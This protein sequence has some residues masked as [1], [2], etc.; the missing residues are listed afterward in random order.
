MAN[1][2][3]TKQ[4]KKRI[5]S[6]V[7]SVSLLF[8]YLFSIEKNSQNA[9]LQF[10]LNT[11]FQHSKQAAEFRSYGDFKSAIDSF[12]EA[13]QIAKKIPDKEKECYSLL[14]LGLMYWNVGNLKIS[15]N[16]Y[17]EAL[18]IAKIL[19][20]K[21]CQYESQAALDI[22]SLYN[23]GKK[24]RSS[25]D[26]QKSIE[27]FQKAIQL[28][29][30]IGSKEHEVKC[31]RQLSTVYWNLNNLQ[32]FGDLNKNGLKIA[33][34]LNHKKEEGR[35]LNN[36]GILHKKL[37][38]YSKALDSF[39]DALDI[40]K[41]L[42][43]RQDESDIL[44]NMGNIYKNIGNFEKSLDYL[45]KALMIDRK[46]G[47]KIYIAVDLFNIGETYRNKGLIS[48]SKQNLK[49]ALDHFNE[50]I[51]I[52][53]SNGNQREIKFILN[54]IQAR[55]LNNIG[56][57]YTDLE[58]YQKALD[59]FKQGYEKAETVQ[60]LEAKGM[61]LNNIGIVHFNLGNYEESTKYYQKA[62]DL[63]QELEGGQILW[64]AYFEIGNALVEQNKLFGALKNYKNSVQIIENIRSQLKLEELKAKYL[65]ADKRIEVYQNL[66]HLLISLHREHQDLGFD[67]EAFNYLERAKARSFLDSL[68]VA[69]VDISFGINFKLKN[70]E[71]E[72]MK[73]ISNIYNK[74]LAAE[75]T[76]EEKKEILQQL[77]NRENDLET[78]KREIRTKSPHYADLKYPEIIKT[79]EVQEKLLDNKSAFIAYTIGKK[80][81]YGFL[82]TK[83]EIKIFPLPKKSEI[84]LMLSDYIKVI[85]DKDNRDFGKG[86]SLFTSL[87]PSGLGKNIKNIIF[88]PDDIL[89]FLP[90]ETLVTQKDYVRWLIEDYKIA[91]APSISSYREIIQRKKRKK[92][93]RRYDIVAFGDPDFGH[94]ES[95]SNGGDI[96]QNFY[97][98]NAF[99]FYRLN[100]SGTE[101]EKI[102]SLF[103]DKKAD[104]F[105]RESANE[106]QLKKHNLADYKIIHFATHSLI[107]DQ[108]PAR[109]SIILSL[110]NGTTEDGFVQTREI[111]NLDL[112]SDL[113]TLSSCQTGLGQF[114]KG[115]GIEGLNRAFFFAGASSVLMSLWSVNDQATYQLMERF[116]TYL[117]SSKS[118]ANSLRKA[119]LQMI[120]SD[121]VSHPYYWAGF[122]V[123]GKA[124][125]SVFP[126]AWKRWMIVTGSFILAGGLIFIAI[127][128]N[129][130]LA[131]HP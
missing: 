80:H 2:Y 6:I 46:I 15:S 20:L 100:Y 17:S 108:K 104:V 24:F 77:E 11:Y 119:K 58:N 59:F 48:N 93:K 118:I 42:G 127:R 55:T 45:S 41:E 19:D 75:L 83:K 31:I 84:Q 7:L 113:V 66:I 39:E 125:H 33:K 38:N 129:G 116:Y 54:K 4:V 50:C 130:F 114:I 85:T 61:I 8:S 67:K 95:E 10:Q 92:S 91:Y 74:L 64:E 51:S 18:S 86:Y 103:K 96:F 63:A 115:E 57:V 128:R 52:T 122:I 35:Y 9:D 98:S 25:G 107:D 126:N 78:L 28:A 65:G 97:S 49:K 5:F 29:R 27:S 94:L 123:S 131:R 22:Y 47:N 44:N 111:Y 3:K 36:I 82:L 79:K 89:H 121:A 62:I 60:D 34:Q 70:R 81:S 88:I 106:E 32:R 37:N 56:S 117:R 99:N 21:K 14:K 26:N 90:F 124:V 102:Q 68:E 101:I 109:S 72:L 105:L 69:Q 87:F 40:A 110:S 53:E 43:N 1:L 112:N 16:Y 13:L 23:Q 73:D 30:D 71:K 120:A 12:T 76:S